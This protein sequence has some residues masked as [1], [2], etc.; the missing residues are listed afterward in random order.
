MAV[1]R[2]TNTDVQTLDAAA[3]SALGVG[4]DA[5]KT[6]IQIAFFR[7][8]ELNDFAPTELVHHAYLHLMGEA[9][10]ATADFSTLTREQVAK[11]L[12]QQIQS[13]ANAMFQ[14]DPTQRRSQ[15][16]DLRA[17]CAHSVPLTRRIMELAPGLDV[18]LAVIENLA[19]DVRALANEILLTFSRPWFWREK[20]RQNLLLEYLERQHVEPKWRSPAYHLRKKARAVAALDPL[21]MAYLDIY[22]SKRDTLKLIY[23][24]LGRPAPVDPMMLKR[25]RIFYFLFLIA[26]ALG[27]TFTGVRRDTE[28]RQRE[29]RSKVISKPIN[30]HTPEKEFARRCKMLQ[31]SLN[32]KG[33]WLEYAEAVRIV[34]LLPDF[35][36]EFS[37]QVEGKTQLEMVAGARSLLKRELNSRE[38][39]VNDGE[40]DALMYAIYPYL[41]STDDDDEDDSPEAKP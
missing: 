5:S 25:F 14:L 33:V 3:R 2:S 20:S 11:N 12:E 13:F 10:P 31:Q 18:D 7:I 29:S 41:K 36:T 23:R 17:R 9:I 19:P 32:A 40:L 4:D 37:A 27:S 8:L 30:V 26:I 39:R 24:S 15:W 35:V 34:A 21:L 6:E 22:D 28:K 38:I 16:N 1:D